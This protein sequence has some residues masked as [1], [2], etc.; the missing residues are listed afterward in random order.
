MT[1]LYVILTIIALPFIIAIFMSAPFSIVNEV[2]VNK[3]KQQVFDYLKTLRNQE[4]YSK[5]VMTDPNMRKKFTGTDGTVGFIYAWNS[6]NKQVGQ[7]EQEIIKLI[8]GEMIEN[9][10]R[11][12][13]PFNGISY[14]IFQT[15]MVTPEQTHVKWTFSGTKKYSMKVMHLLFNL[16]KI[17][18]KD[19]QTSLN[20]LKANLEK[21]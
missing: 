8:D 17:L 1:V 9:E 21:Q 10:I 15:V 11:F 18:S 16:D 12:L 13:K 19:M 14:A 4:Q 3:P 5:W 7:G 2:I 20:T 6:D